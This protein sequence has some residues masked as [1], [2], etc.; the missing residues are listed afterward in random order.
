MSTTRVKP[1]SWER[2][3]FWR[4]TAPLGLKGTVSEVELYQIRSRMLRGRLNK[5]K[6]GELVLPLPVGLDWDPVTN[7]PRLAVDES[8]RQALEMVFHLFRQ[9]RSIRGVL[10]YLRQEGLELPY[11]RVRRRLGRAISWRRPSYDALYLIL[12]SPAYAGVYCYGKREKRVD[13]I[14][15][16]VHV[17]KRERNEWGVFIPDH[18]PGYID[19]AHRCYGDPICNRAGAKRVDALVAVFSPLDKQLNLQSR[20]WSEGVL[21]LTAWPSGIV[22]ITGKQ[23]RFWDKW[24][25]YL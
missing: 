18:H 2:T 13:P 24:G 15:Q 16:T 9:L 1:L 21:K 4:E 25:R 3:C 19:A 8:V 22:W 14:T 11:R 5:A 6:R 23:K 10:H 7:K 17:R 12:T 20:H